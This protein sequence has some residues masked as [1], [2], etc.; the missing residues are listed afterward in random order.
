MAL[1]PIQEVK[2]ETVVAA[3]EPIKAPETA[4]Q[5]QGCEAYR[6]LVARYTWDQDVAYA[7]MQAENRS[8]DPNVTSPVNK[9]GS[10]DRGLFQV[11]SIHADMVDGDLSRLYDPATNVEIAYRIYRGSGWTAWSAYKSGV[12]LKFL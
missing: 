12:Y 2:P 10:V 1:H 4:P 5:P 11:N 3:P 7:V 8:C 9:N 6:H